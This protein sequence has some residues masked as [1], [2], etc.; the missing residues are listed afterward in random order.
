MK[1]L[2]SFLLGMFIL[3]FF[4]LFGYCFEHY[5]VPTIIFMCIAISTTI[6]YTI[7]DAREHF[8]GN[9]NKNE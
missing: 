5:E 2:K 7:I 1:L 8:Y 9:S 4:A 3:G 6:G